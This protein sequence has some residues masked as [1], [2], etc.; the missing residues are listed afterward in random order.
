MFNENTKNCRIRDDQNSHFYPTRVGP[1]EDVLHL[2]WVDSDKM[3]HISQDN[4]PLLL[5]VLYLL[6][7]AIA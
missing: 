6:H 5:D 4:V 7:C 1:L 2:L 3:A